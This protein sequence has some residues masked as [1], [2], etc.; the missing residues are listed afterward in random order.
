VFAKRGLIF[1]GTQMTRT[2]T[3][4]GVCQARRECDVGCD[5]FYTHVPVRGPSLNPQYPFTPGVVENYKPRQRRLLL[6]WMLR[7]IVVVCVV[8]FVSGF[9]RGVMV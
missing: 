8:G 3:D 2:C 5:V 6:R 4:L 1:K 7:A 9:V